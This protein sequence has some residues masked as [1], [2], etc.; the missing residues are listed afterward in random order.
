MA[1]SFFWL[2]TF[3]HRLRCASAIARRALGLRVRRGLVLAG[4][5][6][7]LVGLAWPLPVRIARAWRS[8]AI[9]SSRAFNIWSFKEVP[10]VLEGAQNDDTPR[11]KDSSIDVWGESGFPACGL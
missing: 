8:F 4:V 1:G 7:D 5:L 11:G 10:F 2:F 9:S 3:A 6:A